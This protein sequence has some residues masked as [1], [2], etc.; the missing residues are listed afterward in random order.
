MLSLSVSYTTQKAAEVS[1]RSVTQF[2]FD[3]SD[4]FE[5]CRSVESVSPHQQ[6]L[7]Q[8]SSDIT[9]GNIES[10]RQVRKSESIVNW[11]DVSNSISRIDDNSSLKT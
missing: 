7:D 3:L 1:L 9:T 11:H 8:V 2:L 10:L 4:R 5:I 6:Q